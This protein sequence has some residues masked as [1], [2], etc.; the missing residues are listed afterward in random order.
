ME[1]NISEILMKLPIFFYDENAFEN[2]VCNMMTIWYGPQ[3]V[4]TQGSEI[5]DR[6]H[7]GVWLRQADS[8]LISH[9]KCPHKLEILH[10]F[11]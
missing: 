8:D 1:K 3:C 2:V 5:F 9:I 6:N 4:K 7:P 10:N 11:V